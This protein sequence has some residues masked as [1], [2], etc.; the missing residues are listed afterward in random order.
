MKK[1]NTILILFFL[2]FLTT[3]FSGAIHS[4]EVR[5]YK[6]NNKIILDGILNEEIWTNS[7]VNQFTQRD[8]VEGE[9]AS[10]KSNVWVAYDDENLYIAAKLYDSNP[11]SI[12][13]SLM[14]RDSHNESDWFFFFVDPYNDKRTGYYFAVNPGGSLWDGVL[15]NDSWDDDSW[16]GVWEAKTFIDNDGWSFEMKIP[17]S[18]LRFRNSEEMIWGVN[19]NRDIKRKKESS[20]YVMVPKEESGFVSHFAELK[21]L[22]GIKPKQRF[23]VLPYVVQKAQFLR[24]YADDPFY[25]GN[26]YRTSIGA[27]LK[28]GLGSNMTID[29]TINPDFGQV[30]VDP[31]VVNL[32]AFETYFDEKRPFFIEG[33]NIF[34]FGFGG[35]NNNWGFNFGIPALF[36]SRRVGR[37]PQGDIVN[38]GNVD[39]PTETRIL[40]AAKLTGKLADSWSFGAMSAV[41]ERTFAKVLSDEGLNIKEEVEPLT[42]Y[43]V[44]RTLK[45][46]NS[47]K[48][49]IGMIFTSV[50]RDLSDPNLNASLADQ[51]Y[52]FGLDG[53]TMI[54]KDDE[55][56]LNASVIGSYT[57]GSTDYLTSLQKRP[58][59]YFQRPDA[60]F[61]RLNTNRNY[62]SG[63]Y[64][65]I[66]LNKQKGNFY[67]NTALGLIS[68]GFENNDLGFQWMADRING[69]MVMG[70]RWY[71]PDG[72]F[73]RK[74]IYLSHFRTY[75][76]DGDVQT[77]GLMLFSFF[78]F[79]NY[80]NIEFRGGY[81]FERYSPSLT[82]GGPMAK[83]PSDYFFDMYFS[84]D[85]RKDIIV[86]LNG[87]Y[88]RDVLKSYYMS[89]GIELE[90]KPSPQLNLSVGPGYEYRK[91]GFQWVNNINDPAAVNTY[92]TRHI[93]GRI[94]Q[95]TVSGNIR[96]NWTFTPQLSLQLFLQPLFSVGKYDQFKELAAPKTYETNIYGENSSTI[97]YDSDGDEYVVDP[98]GN[99][100]VE[101]F[102][103]SNPDF[104]FKSL[105]GNLVL[106]YE[107]FPGSVF[108]FVWTH[109]KV[110]FKNPGDFKFGRDFSDL[111][112]SVSNNIFLV[113]FSYWLD[114]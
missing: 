98:D 22:E 52:T 91:E 33:S 2:A 17:F 57:H 97:T 46:I 32:S 51:A 45:E 72:L 38:D 6:I 25:K 26:Q 92:Q 20:Y 16:D 68:P 73:R 35:V 3:S 88:S 75:N 48:Q 105:R 102:R 15:Y 82:R 77:N 101:K 60:S 29:A 65:R 40:G 50:N 13:A 69:H 62:L 21:G 53:W 10:E 24:H 67:I 5:A 100:P 9:T 70:Y 104:N 12:D 86:S 95:E 114:V 44:V 66:M 103:F 87:E 63:Y 19:F 90:W 61:A 34:S 1:R 83:I 58:Y 107:V 42:H 64:S 78:Q 110:N 71:E 47:G 84:T 79:E 7:P 11:D 37:S 18:Q 4:Q 80:Y 99:G 108:F 74:N 112:R 36:Y 113:K 85:S 59:R 14:R 39:Y 96:V 28:V 43:G 41:T 81:D 76:F 93:F 27:D 30:E 56:A 54:G 89:Y 31:A 55:Y 109:D 94:N 106:R 8:P 23:E 111:W 49:G